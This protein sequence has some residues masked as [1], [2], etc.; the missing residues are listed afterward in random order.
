ME[1]QKVIVYV[2]G[3]NFY[4]GLRRGF[5]K[6]YY[7]LDV[8]SFFEQ[9][10]KPNQE[11]VKVKYFSARPLDFEKNKRQWDWF[12]A[13]KNNPKFELI[14][15]KYLKKDKVCNNCGYIIHSYEEKET[16]VNI[17]VQLVYDTFK[18]NCDASIV[19]SADS[20]MLPALNILQEEHHN[21]FM[22]FPPNQHS[23]ALSAI[24]KPTLLSRYEKR[25]K[26]NIFSDTVEL[27]NGYSVTIS[28]KWKHLQRK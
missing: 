8:V 17:A 13:N 5:W 11:L 12:M 25:F 7:W 3:F 24:S 23:S 10:M 21:V 16:D 28:N 18:K 9:F 27:K 19:V 2:D 26:A 22:Y 4:Y 6:K 14:L 1:K 20:D 15:G